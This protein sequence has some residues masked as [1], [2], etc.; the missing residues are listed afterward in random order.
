M[1]VSLPMARRLKTNRLLSLKSFEPP[2]HGGTKKHKDLVPLCVFVPPWFNKQNLFC[3]F[4]HTANRSRL[5][6]GNFLA[7]QA[8]ADGREK[9]LAAYLRCILVIVYSTVINQFAGGI[10]P[11]AGTR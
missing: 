11:I 1:T 10:K 4:N 5:F 6:H 8:F 2:R 9:V 3:P 7:A